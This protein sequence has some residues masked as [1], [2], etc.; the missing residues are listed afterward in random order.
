MTRE[1]GISKRVCSN[2]SLPTGEGKKERIAFKKE[3]KA[4]QRRSKNAMC[5]EIERKKMT[6]TVEANEKSD[7]QRMREVSSW[8]EIT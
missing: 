6:M 5:E 7:M 2:E 3:L 1:R 8:R 4:K